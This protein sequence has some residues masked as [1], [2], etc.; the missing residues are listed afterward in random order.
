MQKREREDTNLTTAQYESTSNEC[1][2]AEFNKS[3][4]Q[5][6]QH[7]EFKKFERTS[8]FEIRKDT[9]KSTFETSEGGSFLEPFSAPKFANDKVSS[10][11]HCQADELN[12]SEREMSENEKKQQRGEQLG[13]LEE[14]R[15]E[16]YEQTQENIKT[17]EQDYKSHDI[18]EVM[19]SSPQMAKTG[20]PKLKI[21]EEDITKNNITVEQQIEAIS[22][23]QAS[24]KESQHSIEKENKGSD[25]DEIQGLMEDKSTD[26]S[27]K[28][29]HNEAT[30]DQN[31]EASAY[32]LTVYSFNKDVQ[33][34][35]ACT[36]DRNVG[37]SSTT[38]AIRYQEEFGEERSFTG[39][40]NDEAD[41]SFD[42]VGEGKGPEAI[43]SSGK[44]RIE[45]DEKDNITDNSIENDSIPNVAA[46]QEM[47]NNEEATFKTGDIAKENLEMESVTG[48]SEKEVQ[49]EEEE[50]HKEAPTNVCNIKIQDTT[51]SNEQEKDEAPVDNETH[52]ENITGLSEQEAGIEKEEKHK[53]APTTARHVTIQ[54]ITESE[55]PENAE[56]HKE[57]ESTKLGGHPESSLLQ[58]NEPEKN[59][60]ELNAIAEQLETAP[61]ED[62]AVTTTCI[63]GPKITGKDFTEEQDNKKDAE[64]L[65]D[66]ESSAKI[67][68][69]GSVNEL[70][71]EYIQ[72]DSTATLKD[73]AEKS[74]I[75][76]RY[77][78]A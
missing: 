30:I 48:S 20:D 17:E 12:H 24:I 38:D 40:M 25:N 21:E 63:K 37:N 18:L 45:K 3:E 62:D 47:Q 71:P 26:L 22:N 16:E 74:K 59:K 31:S 70:S 36:K 53:E 41:K 32:D 14:I 65:K 9:I 44:M 54:D 77:F 19:E 55:D 60:L 69:E 52:D 57:L 35:N 50:K 7:P 23:Q 43:G 33:S 67:K 58:Q 34:I 75:E 78:L 11:E 10:L 6:N 42:L 49:I 13:T 76:V 51:V 72:E 68:K 4:G 28:E 73:E 27:S 5:L 29:V 66:E 2:L 56:D 46:S 64:K 61:L 8:S 39:V 15:R 1:F